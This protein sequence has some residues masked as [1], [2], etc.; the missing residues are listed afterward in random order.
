M[1]P[2]ANKQKRPDVAIGPQKVPD[3]Y[4]RETTATGRTRDTRSDDHLSSKFSRRG[5]LRDQAARL[6]LVPCVALTAVLVTAWKLASATSA[7]CLAAFCTLSKALLAAATA[8]RT[9][10]TAFSVPAGAFFEAV[11]TRVMNFF[12][13]SATWA[14]TALVTSALVSAA[15]S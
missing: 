2:Y 12:C 7:A 4:R 3:G 5:R 6:A 10:A 15:M 11:S 9:R 8:E 14:S 1:R 13:A